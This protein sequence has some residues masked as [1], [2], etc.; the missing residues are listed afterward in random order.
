MDCLLLLPLLLLPL[1]WLLLLL[2]LQSD[3]PCRHT[4][5]QTLHPLRLLLLLLDQL[6]LLLL[7][8]LLQRSLLL[9][10]CGH[11]LCLTLDSPVDARIQLAILTRHHNI[12]HRCLLI[13]CCC[14]PLLTLLLLLLLLLVVVIG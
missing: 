7:C 9:L 1:C 4:S 14:W 13:F 12:C 3:T 8:W 5:T 10:Q 11:P 2:Q 6:L